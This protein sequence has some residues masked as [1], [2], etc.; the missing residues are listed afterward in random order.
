MDVVYQAISS[1]AAL[2]GE[3]LAVALGFFTLASVIVIIVS[4][5]SWLGLFKFLHLPNPMNTK[6]FQSFYKYHAYYW[7]LFVVAVILH[8]TTGVTHVALPTPGDPD[9][10][11]HWIILGFGVFALVSFILVMA[12]CRSFAGLLGFFT[13]K[14]TLAMNSYKNFYR[15]HSLYWW[16]FAIAVAGHFGASYVHIGLWP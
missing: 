3:R 6:A 5:R 16:L 12:S 2:Y 11:I 4:C 15:F 9:A 1:T 7:W 8:L 14:N 13:G 10:L